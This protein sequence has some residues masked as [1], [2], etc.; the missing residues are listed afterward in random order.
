MRIIPI[1]IEV[2]RWSLDNTLTLSILHFDSCDS[3][4]YLFHIGWYQGEFEI[5]FLF[6]NWLWWWDYI[7]EGK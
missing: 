6:I 5:D 7:L 2:E 4:H 1:E 3:D